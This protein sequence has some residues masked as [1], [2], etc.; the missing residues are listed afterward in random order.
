MTGARRLLNSVNRV[1][2][3][4]EQAAKPYYSS[5]KRTC[6]AIEYITLRNVL[7]LKGKATRV[8][9]GERR[10]NIGDA[11]QKSCRPES[12]GQSRQSEKYASQ[13]A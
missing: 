10:T 13:F 7:P 1:L 5:L 6:F 9:P 11:I 12:C 4:D 3:V 8:D 2:S